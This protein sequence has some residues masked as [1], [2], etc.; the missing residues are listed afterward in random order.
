TNPTS[1]RNVKVV[2][3]RDDEYWDGDLHHRVPT[4][5][6]Y[7][8]RLLRAL[9]TAD[10]SVIALDFDERLP[11]TGA[12]G[13]L[14]DYGE[15]DSYKPYR[16][17]TDE[18]VRAIGEIAERRKIVLSKTIDG[19]TD[20]PFR[21]GGDIFQPYG[22]CTK[23]IGDGQWLNPGTPQFKLSPVAQKNIS[24][25]YIRLMDDR[26]RVPPPAKITGQSGVLDAFPLAIV[27]ARAPD[28]VP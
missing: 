15:I 27:R 22:I 16:D 10:A 28:A 2:I 1:A 8:A 25:G 12:P 21:L 6:A 17:E 20:G 26:R 4:D 14:G 13:T 7:L 18:L 3:I 5:R 9:D 23:L 19:P 24:C 11:H